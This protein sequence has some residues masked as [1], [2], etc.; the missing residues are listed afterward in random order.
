VTTAHLDNRLANLIVGSGAQ[1]TV[2]SLSL[3]I[4]LLTT[5]LVARHLQPTGYG[6]L[7]I[8]MTI[9]LFL[10]MVGDFG[11]PLLASRDW[12]GL[13][14][15]ARRG[16]LGSFWRLRRLVTLA[17]VLL[18]LFVAALG[19]FDPTVR[20]GIALGLVGLSATLFVNAVV[21]LFLAELVPTQAATA[22]IISRMI[23]LAGVLVVVLGTEAGVV[24]ILAASVTSQLAGAIFVWISARRRSLISASRPADRRELRTML[25]G[26]APIALLPVLGIVYAR[27]DI[28][29]LA[30][31]TSQA[32]VGVYGIA[33]RVLEVLL[34]L[35]AIASGLLLPLFSSTSG[36]EAQR[37]LYRACTSILATGILPVAVMVGVLAHSV[38]RLL[39]GDEFLA[40]VTSPS[41]PITAEASLALLMGAFAFMAIGLVNGAVMVARRLHGAL[42]RHFALAILAKVLLTFWLVGRWSFLG[43]AL[44]TFLAEAAAAVHSTMVARAALGELRL[45][46]SL[47]WPAATATVM[48]MTLV[49]THSLPFP[50]RFF[51]G[52]GTAVGLMVTS[53]TPRRFMYLLRQ[54]VPTREP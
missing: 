12:P 8:V 20:L 44:A 30:A 22:E 17:V 51:I 38:L 23:W 36:R 7:T 46:R 45:L 24:G 14:A 25:A 1:L 49:L 31:R 35:V 37:R 26:A 2:R 6:Q 32:E 15:N 5:P 43:A 19:P 41:S 54:A 34:G 42:F 50:L 40:P 27:S 16:W 11:L 10:T 33:W 13:D 4:G 39:A 52:A 3:A 53:G 21:G 18:G 48:G 29:I 28:L 47:A 9:L